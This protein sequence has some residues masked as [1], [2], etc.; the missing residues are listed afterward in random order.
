M[1]ENFSGN[2][3]DEDIEICFTTTQKLHM[4]LFLAKKT[5]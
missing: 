2:D 5:L 3:L 4:D 1:V